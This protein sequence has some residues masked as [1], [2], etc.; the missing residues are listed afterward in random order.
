VIVLGVVFV[1]AAWL[2]WRS[3]VGMFG[4]LFPDDDD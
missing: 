1:G 3:V 2:V 4:G